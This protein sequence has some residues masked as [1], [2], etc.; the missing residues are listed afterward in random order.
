MTSRERAMPIELLRDGR[1][2]YGIG[3][4][5]LFD[6][7]AVA[8]SCGIEPEKYTFERPPGCSDPAAG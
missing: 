3:V 2:V 5:D 7:E 1:G 6:H 4:S 8:W